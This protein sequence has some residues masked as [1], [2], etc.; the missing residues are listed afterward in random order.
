MAQKKITDFK[1]EVFEMQV[2]LR[3]RQ[4]AKEKGAVRIYRKQDSG[5]RFNEHYGEYF[6][7][8]PFEGAQLIFEGELPEEHSVQFFWDKNTE[9]QGCYLYWIEP[10]EESAEPTGPAIV[11]VRDTE[12]WWSKKKIEDY[13]LQLQKDYPEL[14]SVETFGETTAHYPLRAVIVGNRENAIACVGA[15][16]AGESGPELLLPALRGLLSTQAELL[17]KVG[18]AAMV[19][20]NADERE[21]L[22][23]GNPWYLRVN[24]N[25]VD[26]NRNFDG[27]WSKEDFSYGLYSGWEYASIYRGPYVASEPEV[28]AVQ[29]FI[30]EIKPKAVFSYHALASVT[31]DE[32][33]ASRLSKEDKSYDSQNRNFA[34]IYSRTYRSQPGSDLTFETL[35]LYYNASPGSL[36]SFCYVRGIPCVDLEY[37]WTE[38]LKPCINDFTTREMVKECSKRHE[39]ALLAVLK[40]MNNAKEA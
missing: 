6:D 24:G 3:F 30:T 36:P 10:L 2:R 18:I 31:E 17:K 26:L 40:K 22:V 21:K 16:H 14:V 32:M 13:S 12:V 28:Q 19:S 34:E 11:K 37:A 35:P 4:Y 27:N 29:R 33:L 15:I 7:N 8:I 23:R 39:A 25:G 1:A 5:F 20:V 38:A 9:L